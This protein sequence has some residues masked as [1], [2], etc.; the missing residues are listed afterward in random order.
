ME[1]TDAQREILRSTFKKGVTV[2]KEQWT[3]K[4]NSSILLVDGT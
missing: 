2:T 3:R 4:T 1:L